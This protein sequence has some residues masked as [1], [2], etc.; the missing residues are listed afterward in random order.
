[1]RIEVEHE[2]YGDLLTSAWRLHEEAFADLGELAVRRHLMRRDEF[3]GVMIDPRVRKYLAFDAGQ[4]VGLSA[5]TNDLDALPLISPA[6]FRRRWPAH[7]AELRIWYCDFVAVGRDGEAAFAA[8][9]E[10]ML[11]LAEGENGIVAADF[12]RVDD[13]LRRVLEGLPDTHPAR[14]RAECVDEQSY[15]VYRFNSPDPVAAPSRRPA[16]SAASR[17]ATPP[18]PRP[19]T[20]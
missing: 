19:R 9:M 16:G 3:V 15:R 20:T 5:F 17:G 2:V 13:R 4:L 6:Y 1:M 18:P 10:A 7:Y 8:L 11:A 12:C 14:M